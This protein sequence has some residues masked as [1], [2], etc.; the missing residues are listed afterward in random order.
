MTA[1]EEGELLALEMRAEGRLEVM[2]RMLDYDLRHRIVPGTD[3]GVGSLAF[4]HLDYDLQLL[5]QVGFTPAEALLSATRI[6]A[7]AI[8]LEADLGTIQPGKIADL[9]AFAGDPTATLAL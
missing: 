5:V 8:G 9:V 1:Q 6:S 2:R 3:S 7:E 4:G